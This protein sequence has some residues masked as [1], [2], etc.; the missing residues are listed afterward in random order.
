[1]L[2]LLGLACGAASAAES[3]LP[4]LF[5]IGGSTLAT[6]PDTRPVVGWGQM[7]PRFFKDPAQV[8]NRGKSGRSTKSFIDQGLW[9]KVRT[10]LGPGDF[11]I[12][13][14]GGGN[15]SKDDPQRR[16]DPHG[17][18]RANL[19]H[20]IRET[21]AKGAT[22][23]L[24][25]AVARREWDDQGRFV[26]P[27]SEYVVVTREV[28]AREQAP[29]ME[30]RGATVA[31][32]RSLGVEGSI[33]LHLHLPAGAHPEHPQG[34]KD[35]THYNAHGALEVARLAVREIRRLGLPLVDWLR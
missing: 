12:I 27:P 9:E 8:D 26:E 35:N 11:L 10:D 5:L 34:V 24:A 22:P 13:A 17:S 1:M 7:L 20:F 29:L 3:R 28:A 21:R 15:E 4:K 18:Y 33:A 2:A 19:E 23:I 32:E 30:L 25:T 31:L 14:F 6:F 16:T